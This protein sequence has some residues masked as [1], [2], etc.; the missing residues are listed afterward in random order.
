MDGAASVFFVS[1]T[2]GIRDEAEA[3]AVTVHG[4]VELLADAQRNLPISVA[5]DAFLEGGSCSCE[6]ET[7]VYDTFGPMETLCRTVDLRFPLSED[8]SAVDGVFHTTVT[9]KNET[10]EAAEREIAYTAEA[11]ICALCYALDADGGVHYSAQKQT[12]PL[13]LDLPLHAALLPDG[14]ICIDAEVGMCEG[15]FDENE[16]CIGLNLLFSVSD[17]AERSEDCVRRIVRGEQ[18][19]LIF[20][21]TYAVYYPTAKD[22]LWTIAKRYATSPAAIAACNHLSAE[23]CGTHVPLPEMLLIDKRRK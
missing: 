7:L 14:K 9:L 6:M 10:H 11:E 8:E 4:I 22:S 2:C 20:V 18:E 17:R 16:I 15:R 19:S 13:H 12:V 23:T 21:P 5:S 3:P 1:L